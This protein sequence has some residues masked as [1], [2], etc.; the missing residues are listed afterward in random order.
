MHDG[1]DDERVMRTGGVAAAGDLVVGFDQH[2][3]AVVTDAM[4]C[5]LERCDLTA[6]G[7]WVVVF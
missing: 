3:N 5:G 7:D 1:V 2:R 4:R 6:A